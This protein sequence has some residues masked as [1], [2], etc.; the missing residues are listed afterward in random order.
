M[1]E[2]YVTI[3]EN[4]QH[5]LLIKKSQFICTLT[6]VTSKEA[7]DDFIAATKKANPKANHNC[8]AYLIG[9]NDQIQRESDDG[10]P[11]GTAGVPILEVLKR[12][13][14]HNVAAV[15]T[16]Y[17]GGIKLGAGGLIRA[18]SNATSTAL[19]SVGLVNRVMQTALLTT[20]NYANFEKLSY[21]LQQ[22]QIPVADTAYAES[23]TV[24]LMVSETAIEQTQAL[25][26]DFLSGQVTFKLGDQQYN[27][28]PITF[29][30]AKKLTSTP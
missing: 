28:V 2:N 27:D 5:E 7:A 10:E 9:Q 3:K 14:V 17:F 16:R 25:I 4:G 23:V 18:Y 6:R 11:S 15:V 24:T 19:E 30:A 29:E 20:I 1:S 12:V 21:F 13:G 22:Q 8:F 26:T